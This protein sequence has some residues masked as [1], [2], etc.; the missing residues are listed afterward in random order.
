MHAASCEWE[1]DV[2]PRNL[3]VAQRGAT[4]GVAIHVWS[5]DRSYTHSR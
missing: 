4:H 3:S 2:S 5:R 1:D